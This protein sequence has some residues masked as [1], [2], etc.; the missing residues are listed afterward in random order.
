L[1]GLHIEA[2]GPGQ[3]GLDARF[4]V[5]DE[6]VGESG[7]IHT[8]VLTAALHE[9]M[10]LTLHAQ[11]VHA[12]AVH[13]E[14]EFPGTAPPGALIQLRTSIEPRDAKTIR[15]EAT[16]RGPES[17]IAQAAGDFVVSAAH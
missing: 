2:D 10:A 13:V 11:G 4:V 12:T 5:R 17:T 9:A 3:D 14:V 8:G 1:L 6:H 16:A 7:V 15:V